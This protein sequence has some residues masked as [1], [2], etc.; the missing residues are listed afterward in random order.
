[1]LMMIFMSSITFNM[2]VNTMKMK[3]HVI[4]IGAGWAGFGAA[5]A[6][7]DNNCRVTLFDTLPDPSGESPFLSPTGKPFEAGTR[8]F[9]KDYPNIEHL[10]LNE[11][12]QVEAEVFTPFTNSSFYSPFG[13]EATAPVFSDNKKY[14]QLPS[15]IGQVLASAALFERIPIADRA[16]M[17]GLMYA[18]LDVARDEETMAAYDRM[19]A[20]DLFIKMKVSKR[21]VEDFI[22][23]TLLVGLFKPPEELSALVVMELLYYYA[24][25]HQDSFDVRW[26]KSKSIAEKILNPLVKKL[27]TDHPEDFRL[28]G[29]HRV[30]EIKVSA[31]SADRVSEVT[32]SYSTG[33]GTRS[34][35]T[36]TDIDACVI[37]VGAK[38][39]K[40]VM[41]GSPTLAKV[42]TE[43]CRAASLNSIDVIATRIWLDKVVPTRSPVNVFS[44]FEGLRGAGGT[45]FLLDQLQGN[46]P[47][48]WGGEEPRGSVVSCDLYNAAALLPLS[49]ADI[50]SLFVDELLPSAVPAFRG[51]KVLDSYV[52]RCPGAVSWFSPG[53][54][55]CRPPLQLST[56]KNAVCAGDWVRMG[57]F[58]HGS[59]GL[60]QERAYVSGIQAANA[61]ARSGAL[62]GNKK[63]HPVIAIRE[64]EVQVKFGREVIKRLAG[65]AG[66]AGINSSPWIR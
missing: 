31:E 46:T 27:R 2:S 34:S 63:M 60:C 37:A 3:P 15:P 18:I 36:E 25:A 35:R 9:W 28:L 39:L 49:D 42:S 48:L 53:S 13:L 59:K 33:P 23:P 8:G 11:L 45:F 26:I 14:L 50:V 4:V 41:A 22:K 6:L 32:Y 19:S 44:R 12:K 24:L 17:I 56:V 51:A 61:L 57:E 29:G 7:C 64:D 62:N 5:K 38:G 55:Y 20:H 47:E 58:E 66:L 16:S 40:S 52:L 10:V 1:M 65:L 54:Y 30:D 43:L 21:L